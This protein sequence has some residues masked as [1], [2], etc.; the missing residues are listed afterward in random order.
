MFFMQIEYDLEIELQ[1]FDMW[2]TLISRDRLMEHSNVR[3]IT[4]SRLNSDSKIK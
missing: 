2:I 3:S 1:I 4:L